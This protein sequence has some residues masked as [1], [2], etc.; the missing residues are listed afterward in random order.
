MNACDEMLNRKF[1]ESSLGYKMVRVRAK[2][3]ARVDGWIRM[4][5]ILTLSH[6]LLCIYTMHCQNYHLLF[7]KFNIIRN[8]VKHPITSYHEHQNISPPLLLWN[9]GNQLS[10]SPIGTKTSVR[11]ISS[12]NSDLLQ[13]PDSFNLCQ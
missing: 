12:R 7:T 10:F 8:T 1:S 4:E 9:V 11:L 13:C 3:R 2:A 5:E 6:L